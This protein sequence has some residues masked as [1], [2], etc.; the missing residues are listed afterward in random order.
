MKA[1]AHILNQ[2]GIFVDVYV[3]DFYGADT[4]E[5]AVDSFARMTQLFAEFGLQS[6]PDKDTPPTRHTIKYGM[7]WSS[8]T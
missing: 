1:V 6:S 3:D 5:N 4:S 8:K 7:E 2:E